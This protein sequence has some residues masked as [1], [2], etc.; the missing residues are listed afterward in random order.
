M[1]S[2]RLRRQDDP[3]IAGVQGSSNIASKA[4]DHSCVARGRLALGG[5][6]P[7]AAALA[8]V[9][10]RGLAERGR[11]VDDPSLALAI[12]LIGDGLYYHSALRAEVD[13]GADDAGDEIGRPEMDAL[14]ALL[15][16]IARESR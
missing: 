1:C 2:V 6:P 8:A 11:H 10:G 5:A 13:P 15:E 9:G 14:V 16:R 12:T 4:I 7:A 3:G